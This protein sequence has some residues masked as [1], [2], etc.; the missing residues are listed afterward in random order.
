[1]TSRAEIASRIDH[2]L[3]KPDCSERDIR[4]LCL[5]AHRHHFATV[6]ILPHFVSLAHEQL[7]NSQVR[8]CTVVG[9]PLGANRSSIKAA[10][11]ELAVT[12]GAAEID[13]VMNLAAFRSGDLAHVKQDIRSVVRSVPSGILVK[14]ILETALLN[15]AE[16][17]SACSICREA[18][19][20]FVKTST[21][22][23][24]GGATV[25]AV[26]VMKAAVRDHMGVK[27][28]GGIRTLEQVMAM[29][30]AGADRIGTSAGIDIILETGS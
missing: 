11:A 16:I 17:R 26:R 8:V 27:A 22:F 5:E 18:G 10:E 2:T 23:G 29:I 12:E 14:V 28:S 6:C 9:F 13:M 24:P 19:A 4:R 20:H 1:M 30:A 3:L 15:E 25:E 7:R 21:G